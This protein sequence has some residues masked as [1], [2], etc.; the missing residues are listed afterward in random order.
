M[1]YGSLC[2]SL[3][4]VLHYELN[5]RAYQTNE[6]VNT[7][8]KDLTREV[9][10]FNTI[11]QNIDNELSNEDEDIILVAVREQYIIQSDRVTLQI[12]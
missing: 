5:R 4:N 7:K 1:M 12:M 9:N 10:I 8:F 11:Y 6:E 3:S 2:I